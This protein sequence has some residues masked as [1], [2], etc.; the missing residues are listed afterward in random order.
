M[1]DYDAHFRLDPAFHHL[2]HA[3]VAPW[4]ARTVDAVTAFAMENGRIGSFEYDRWLD[5]EQR[6][7]TRLQRLI[8]ARG[9]D[10]IA[11]LKNTSEGL[12][13]IA[14]GIDWRPGDNVV[15][16]D[17]EFPSNR[18]VWEALAAHGVETRPV[19]L[20]GEDPEAAILSAVDSRTRLVSV[21]SVQYATGLRLDLQRIGRACEQRGVLFCIDAIQSL[22]AEPFDVR[23]YRADFVVADGHKWMLGP[24]GVALFYC[25]RELIPRLRLSEYGWHMTDHPGDFDRTDWRPAPDARRF[26]CGSPNLLGIH[27]LEASLSLIEEIGLETIRAEILARVHRLHKALAALADYEILTPMQPERHLG[28]FTF[29]P[30]RV[31]SERLYR[32]LR[33]AGVFCALRGGG[34]RLSPHFHTRREDLD[35]VIQVLQNPEG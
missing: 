12:S 14:Q 4:P 29:R 16:T 15:I 6:L 25:R 3:A 31:P 8:G 18:I 20:T 2:N 19:P 34:I 13:F 23:R 11:L 21:S 30:R 17:Q 32:R 22:G 10:E 35:A 27:A 1:N 26:E 24:E 5:T 7:R 33:Q 9:T 28:I